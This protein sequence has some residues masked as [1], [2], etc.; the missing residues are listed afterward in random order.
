MGIFRKYVPSFEKDDI[1]FRSKVY[2][3]VLPIK[4]MFIS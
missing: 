3:T 1:V 4:N 2:G